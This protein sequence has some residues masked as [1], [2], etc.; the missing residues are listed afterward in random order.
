M[1]PGICKWCGAT[2]HSSQ[3][4]E[5]DFCWE[6]RHRIWIHPEM[7]QR[8]LD[9]FNEQE[10]QKKKV[11]LDKQLENVWK[12]IETEFRC[13]HCGTCLDP[14]GDWLATSAI[15]NHTVY[16][17]PTCNKVCDFPNSTSSEEDEEGGDS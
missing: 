15:L 1:I 14:E 2:L 16:L 17:C 5:C 3:I 4:D 10:L 13:P 12:E 6:L 9:T 7:A 8:M 11:K